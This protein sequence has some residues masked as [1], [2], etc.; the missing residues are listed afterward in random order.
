MASLIERLKVG[1]FKYKGS[2]RTFR[3]RFVY[4]SIVTT[5]TPEDILGECRRLLEEHPDWR[6]NT[7]LD[8]LFLVHTPEQGYASDDE[9][10]PYYRVKRLLLEHGI[11]CQMVD[12]PT[13]QNPDWKDLNLALNIVAKCGVTPWVLPDRIPDADFFIG[14]S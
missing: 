6:G 8:R 5:P 7:R 10:S 1:K 12:T 3:T 2:E 11:P 9:N 13:L 4:N 14:L